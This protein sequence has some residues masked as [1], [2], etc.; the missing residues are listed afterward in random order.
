MA[1]LA[2][3]D[4]HRLGTA[5]GPSAVGPEPEECRDQHAHERINMRN[6]VQRQPAQH[7]GRIVPL[8]QRR[9]S[10]RILV[11]HKGEDENGQDEYELAQGSPVFEGDDQL[12]DWAAIYPPPPPV[13]KRPAA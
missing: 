1:I 4:R 6:R 7:V 12:L 8:S 10:V 2:R 9:G 11:R 3:I 5:E 13:R